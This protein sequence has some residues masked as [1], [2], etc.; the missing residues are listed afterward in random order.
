[1]SIL[2]TSA[3]ARALVLA[4]CALALASLGLVACGGGSTAPSQQHSAAA[5]VR[6]SGRSPQP[7]HPVADFD[8]DDYEA[9]TD[10]DDDDSSP[11]PDRDGDADGEPGRPY[12]RD[13]AGVLGLGRPAA[14]RD[15]REVQA[16]V[17]SYFA[18]VAAQDGRAACSLMLANVAAHIPEILGPNVPRPPFVHGGNC[19]QIAASVFAFYGRQLRAEAASVRVSAVRVDGASALVL[20]AF[21]DRSGLPLRLIALAREGSGWRVDGMLDNELP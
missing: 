11:P 3:T 21:G 7:R 17:A 13:D 9:G 4:A 5:T 15:T 2:R 14:A 20:L 8:G 10:A 1:V 19:P 18:A 6:A 12:D 16:L